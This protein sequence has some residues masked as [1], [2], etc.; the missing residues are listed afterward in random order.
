MIIAAGSITLKDCRESVDESYRE[1]G[2]EFEACFG[3]FYVGEEVDRLAVGMVEMLA[4]TMLHISCIFCS[5]GW[6]D[7]FPSSAD[8]SSWRMAPAAR[9]GRKSI[10]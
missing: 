4:F 1:L 10:M 5:A 6:Y 3:S 2:G 9:I 8:L 7:G